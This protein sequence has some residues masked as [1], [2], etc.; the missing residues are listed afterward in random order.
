MGGGSWSSAT[1]THFTSKIKSAPRAAVFKNKS[2]DKDLDPKNI[3]FRESR[4]SEEHPNS[5][6]IVVMFDVTGS[7]GDI[8]HKFAEEL[9]GDLMDTL[10]DADVPDPQILVG[11]VGDAYSDRA[12]LQISQWESDNRVSEW[13]TKIF[14][15]GNGGGT[16][17]E[18]YE[19]AW[20]W[21]SNPNNVSMDCWEKRGQK[22]IFFTI[23]D[24]MPYRSI[25][26]NHVL[27]LTSNGIEADESFDSVI[28][29][30]NER[31]EAFHIMITQGYNFGKDTRDTWRALIGERAIEVNDYNTICD[32]IKGT[33]LMVCGSSLDEAI[34]YAKNKKGA[35]SALVPLSE[36]GVIS[37]PVS[38]K[39]VIAK[40]PKHGK[41]ERL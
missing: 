39:G 9:L 3:D 4:D 8:P 41:T 22:G 21:F 12:P 31:W 24:E 19:L 27:S 20:Y 35:E 2:L 40:M 30:M 18:S 32:V 10:I 38:G 17:H 16:R 28:R 34:S 29:R 37:A 36:S 13:L 5:T 15:E 14:I 26:K 23:G 25:R 33:T 6:P 11:A 7:M 1:Y